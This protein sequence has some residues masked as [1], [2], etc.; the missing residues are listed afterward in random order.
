MLLRYRRRE[1][2]CIDLL[3]LI[4]TTIDFDLV[5]LQSCRH[6]LFFLVS[7]LSENKQKIQTRALI[8]EYKQTIKIIRLDQKI[9]ELIIHSDS[10][11]ILRIWWT[12]EISHR[13]AWSLYLKEQSKRSVKNCVK[14]LSWWANLNSE[15]ASMTLIVN[16]MTHLLSSLYLSVNRFVYSFMCN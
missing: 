13:T 7:W 1:I 3:C 2:I 8:S 6:S 11:E 9:S 10:Q 15:S 4:H 16:A 14:S 12:N 5:D